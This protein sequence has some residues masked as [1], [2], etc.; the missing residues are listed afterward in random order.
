[1]SIILLKSNNGVKTS[2]VVCLKEDSAQGPW[3]RDIY[4]LLQMVMDY[5]KFSLLGPNLPADSFGSIEG[6]NNYE[7]LQNPL[8]TNTPLVAKINY[9]MAV[10]RLN[11]YEHTHVKS[12]IMAH[13]P[14][15]NNCRRI[16]PIPLSPNL[17]DTA[18]AEWYNKHHPLRQASIT[19][20]E[21]S[22]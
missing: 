8:I 2:Y 18:F 21:L 4:F 22:S 15:Y 9:N 7:V 5:N 10:R 17:H 1:V 11:S 12:H 13:W 14:Y 20:A 16:T 3:P 6:H 19:L